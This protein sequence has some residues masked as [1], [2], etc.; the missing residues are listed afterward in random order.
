MSNVLLVLFY[1]FIFFR[2]MTL[3]FSII[4]LIKNQ[5]V[6]MLFIIEPQAL[7]QLLL[8]YS[9]GGD[10]IIAGQAAK[11]LGCI[12]SYTV[13]ALNPGKPDFCFLIHI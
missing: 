1:Y 5:N 6:P 9:P 12:S 13:T 3:S 8:L 7:L 2:S 10:Q 4:T 11:S